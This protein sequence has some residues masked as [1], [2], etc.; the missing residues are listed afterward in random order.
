MT[1]FYSPT[2]LLTFKKCS[3]NRHRY[4]GWTLQPASDR[5]T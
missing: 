4:K 1:I 5:M 3:A 2:L